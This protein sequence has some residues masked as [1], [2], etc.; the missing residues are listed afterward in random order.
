MCSWAKM[1]YHRCLYS[2]MIIKLKANKKG[3][4][5]EKGIDF[6]PYAFLAN[7]QDQWFL[8]DDQIFLLFLA[9]TI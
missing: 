2:Y 9:N 1:K 3:N 4:Q 6:N 7:D 5:E 8:M